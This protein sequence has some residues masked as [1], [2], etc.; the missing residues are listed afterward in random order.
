MELIPA[1][2]DVFILIKKKY[3]RKKRE[4]LNFLPIITLIIPVYHSRDTLYECIK[5]VNDS[6][7]DNSAIQIM[8]VDNGSDD[9]SYEV[10]LQCREEFSD[11]VMDW[12]HSKQGKS[13]ALNMAL[14]NATGKYIIHIDSDGILEKHALYNM[15]EMFER[16][17]DVHCATGTILTRPEYIDQTKNFFMRL[18]RKVEFFE[19]CQAFLAG[20]NFESESNSVFT[21]SGAF[22]AFRKSTILKTQLYNTDTVCEDTHITFQVRETLGKKISLCSNAIFFVDPIE[23]MNRLYTQRQRW[24]QGELEV[25]HMF[26]QNKK[27][28]KGGFA[29]NFLIRLIIFDHTFAFP[30]MIWYFAL[31]TLLALNYPLKLIIVSYALIYFLSFISALNFKFCIEGFLD[32]FP[33]LQKY[34]RR[35]WYLPILYP[36]FNFMVFWFRMA[37]VI[38]SVTGTRSWKT[39]DMTQEKEEIEKVY[40]KDMG[41]LKRFRER[42]RTF[43]NAENKKSV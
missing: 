25:Y 22:S 28:G 14:F 7:Y 4:R 39:K 11:L 33:D 43:V 32:E 41:F 27:L 35:K 13:K 10:F 37:G 36:L 26:D 6:D 15:V 12:M 8:L 9:G 19:Y 20:R 24:Q 34:V 1:F 40:N 5:A 17:E 18:I 29:R 38:N 2:F 3:K 23:T 21:L 30:R 16:N 31:L 42:A